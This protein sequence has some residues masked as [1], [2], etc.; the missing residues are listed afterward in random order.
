VNIEEARMKILISGASGMVGS[1]LAAALGAEGHTVGRLARPCSAASANDVLWDPEGGGLDSAAAEGTEAIV[2]LAGASIAGARWSTA[3][4]ELLRR[5]RVDA[6]KNLVAGLSRMSSPPRI[7]V[8]ASA[9]GY[10]G[11]RGDEK[12]TEQSAPG[13]D[14]LAELS[15]DWEAASREAETLGARTV[16][17]RF[18]IILSKAGGALPRMLLPFRLGAGG[19][20]GSGKQWMSWITLDDVIGIIQFAL[21]EEKLK[22]LANAVSPHPVRNAEFTGILGLVLRRPTLFPAPAFALRL[23]LGELADALLLGSQRV[24]P[25]RL[26][27]LGYR[28]SYS[29]LE[30][31]LRAVL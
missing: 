18:G 10:Y 16:M 5:S 28:F 27:A 17:L 29:E 19:R 11:D 12:L 7:F 15:R 22:G 30:P 3:R 26:A 9:I 25:E 8:A 4:K 31:A 24:F 23:A 2:H 21:H 1:T 20:L 13:T 14:F 6:T